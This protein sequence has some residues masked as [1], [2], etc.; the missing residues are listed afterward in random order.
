MNHKEKQRVIC[1]VAS[2]SFAEL[3]RQKCEAPKISLLSPREQNNFLVA[4]PVK[5]IKR[6]RGLHIHRR[7]GTLRS[8]SVLG[9]P[10]AQY[11]F[12][13]IIRLDNYEFIG[14]RSFNDREIRNKAVS[15]I[16]SS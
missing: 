1:C 13:T 7:A 5:N 3:D 6:T 8:F 14:L 4:L 16:Y 10:S 9:R 15:G 11:P 2:S 12:S